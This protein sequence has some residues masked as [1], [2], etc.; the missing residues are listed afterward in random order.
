MFQHC[1]TPR[2]ETT[3]SA[4]RPMSACVLPATP[5]LSA[6]VSM[7]SLLTR[8][9]VLL[10]PVPYSWVVQ[11]SRYN[12][13]NNLWICFVLFVRFFLFNL[14]FC[15]DSADIQMFYT[16]NQSLFLFFRGTLF[17]SLFCFAKAC[18]CTPHICSFLFSLLIG[19]RFSYFG[20]RVHV[21][22]IFFLFFFLCWLMLN[23]AILGSVSVYPAY[24]LVYTS[25][26]NR[27]HCDS[28]L[29]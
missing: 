3:V 12:P 14:I 26:Y 13:I 18:P 5:D 7:T 16:S 10:F 19:V 21:L 28:S 20:K 4:C 9:V 17:L 15:W 27:R 25:V 22:R 29:A 24:F 11:I 23:W 6:H 8:D 1:A 2:V